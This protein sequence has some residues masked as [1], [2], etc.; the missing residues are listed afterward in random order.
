MLSHLALLVTGRISCGGETCP[1]SVQVGTGIILHKYCISLWLFCPV[2]V[3]FCHVRSNTNNIK[4]A[5]CSASVSLWRHASIADGCGP[6]VNV[7]L[8]VAGSFVISSMSSGPSIGL[9]AC[10]D[11]AVQQ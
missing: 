7:P 4:M 2:F 6:V 10:M 1:Y 8:G 11:S 3:L 5:F 9:V